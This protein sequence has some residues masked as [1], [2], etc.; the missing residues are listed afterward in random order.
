MTEDQV[1]ILRDELHYHEHKYY[2]ENQPEISD[3][4]FDMLMKVLEKL[5]KENPSLITPNSPTQRVG[6]QM[7]LGERIRHHGLMLSLENTYTSEELYDFDRRI[8]KTLPD[9]EIKYVVEL[10][11]DGLGVA[12]NYED[13]YLSYGLTRGDGDFGEDVTANVRTIKSIPLKLKQLNYMSVPSILEV[14]G[15]V[16]I[17]K[18]QLGKV[19]ELRINA[20]ESPFANTRNAAAGSLRLLDSNIV[21][22]RPLDIFIYRLS[23]GVDLETHD[24]GLKMLVDLGFKVNEMANV[25]SSMEEVIQYYYEWRDQ[26][27]NLDYDTDGIVVKVN[28]INHQELLGVRTK[29]PRWAI[30]CKFPAS[31]ATTRINQIEIQ[32]GRTGVLTPVATLDPVEIAGARIKNATLHNEQEIT[33]KDI[34][35]GDWIVLERSGDV[36][37][38]VVSVLAEKRSGWEKVFRFPNTCPSCGEQV[39][40]SEQETAIRCINVECPDQ[41][42]RRIEHFVSRNALNIEG[43]GK[44]TVKQLIEVGLVSNI[45]DLY[46]LQKDDLLVLEGFGDQSAE[47]LISAIASSKQKPASRVLFGLGILHVGQSA[48]DLLIDYFVSIGA[49]SV[50]EVGQIGTIHGIGSRTAESVVDFFA[51]PDNREL[52]DQL[53]LAG[54][55]MRAEA[56]VDLGQVEGS[57]LG[58]T[59][60]LTGTLIGMT[61]SMASERIKLMGGKVSSNVSK[62]TDFLVGGENAGNKKNQAIALGIQILTEDTFLEMIDS[63]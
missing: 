22:Q 42:K 11:V 13:G 4:E 62:N 8:R 5:E 29:S 30:C 28:N 50:A 16:F 19:N 55:R 41:R 2:V 31:Q 45:A 12:L 37:P 26:Y 60:V 23:Y 25:Y 48:A 32:V 3:V 43:L 49:I 40:R 56:P 20:G 51:Q 61:R 6:G 59:F 54:L 46:H 7:V 44:Q 9:Q 57:F 47:N 63:V 39:Q 27:K 24:Q 58:K 18:S 21:T 14:R 1:R 17:P 34:R 33:R 38:K 35:V 15:E 10:K 53:K 36:I 52:F